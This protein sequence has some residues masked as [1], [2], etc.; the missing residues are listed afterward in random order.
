MT[1]I[2]KSEEKGSKRGSNFALNNDNYSSLP[3]NGPVYYKDYEAI[4]QNY[5]LTVGHAYKSA[6]N[7]SQKIELSPAS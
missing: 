2:N 5:S 7:S 3:L 6:K 1:M 4:N